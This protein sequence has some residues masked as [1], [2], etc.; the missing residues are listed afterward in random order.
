MNREINNALIDCTTLGYEPHGIMSA[1]LHLSFSGSGQGFGGYALDIYDKEV[2]ERTPSKM[3]GVF[4]KGVLDTV[5]VSNWEDLKGKHIRVDHT[6]NKIYR[7]G[8]ILKD[9]WFDP[10][11]AFKNIH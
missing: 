4:V 11:E 9:K 6:W 7:I 3:L 8:N 10:E 2:G 1:Y 5:G